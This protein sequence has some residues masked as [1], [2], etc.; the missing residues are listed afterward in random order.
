[1]MKL[2]KT[3]TTYKLSAR[4]WK[5]HNKDNKVIMIKLLKVKHICHLAKNCVLS[6][7]KPTAQDILNQL[8]AMKTLER[9]ITS[10][11]RKYLEKIFSSIS[12]N[13]LNIWI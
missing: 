13:V 7:E 1:M 11:T 3:S 12:W 9:D 10:T 8:G 5:Q 4:P 6:T 2:S